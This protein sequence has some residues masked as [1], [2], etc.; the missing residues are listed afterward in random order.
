M[1]YIHMCHVMMLMRFY[2]QGKTL[3]RPDLHVKLQPQSSSSSTPRLRQQRVT[4]PRPKT[5]H[6]DDASVD[7]SEAS[8]LSSRGKKGS[9]SNLT[10][11][12]FVETFARFLHSASRHTT[13]TTAFRSSGI[14]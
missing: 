9:S 10:G 13:T 7:I 3:D 14:P 8:S 12:P 2:L 4:R 1:T 6:V 11:E 5:I